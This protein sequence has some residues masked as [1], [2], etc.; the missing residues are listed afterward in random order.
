MISHPPLIREDLDSCRFSGQR[1]Y[2][3]NAW[4]VHSG[5]TSKLSSAVRRR[6]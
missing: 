1:P 3:A 5:R 2:A 4:E 6:G